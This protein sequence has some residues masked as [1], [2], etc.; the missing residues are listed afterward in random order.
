MLRQRKTQ[1]CSNLDE[2]MLLI[3]RPSGKQL[4]SFLSG[5]IISKEKM[6]IKEDETVSNDKNTAQVLNT[7]FQTLW[8]ALISLSISPMIL[9]LN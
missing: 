8:V 4:K 5:K 6:T 9:F 3:T 2:K 7:F 1:Y